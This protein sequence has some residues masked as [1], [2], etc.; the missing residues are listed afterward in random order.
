MDFEWWLGARNIEWRCT[1]VGGIQETK[2]FLLARNQETH[3]YFC[4]KHEDLHSLNRNS[5][6][7][8]WVHLRFLNRVQKSVCVCFFCQFR[9]A[10]KT[11]LCVF[12]MGCTTIL[13]LLWS[14]GACVFLWSVQ[15]CHWN[16]LVI[17]GQVQE[18]L[19][20]NVC[21]YNRVQES[22]CVFDQLKNAIICCWPR[23]QHVAPNKNE[24]GVGWDAVWGDVDR[25]SQQTKTWE[26]TMEYMRIRSN[27]FVH[28]RAT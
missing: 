19:L 23:V 15:K 16:V 24:L 17:S 12:L 20:K 18:V 5:R 6:H 21:F 4:K 2:H 13:L 10:C 7:T 26:R 9:I 14:G 22:A 28:S 3:H 11:C 1:L 25:A 8:W 27:D